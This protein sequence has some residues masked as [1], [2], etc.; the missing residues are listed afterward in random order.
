M[1]QLLKNIKHLWHQQ[2]SFKI[3]LLYLLLLVLLV[4]L[5]PVLP[6]PFGPNELDLDHIFQEPFGWNSGSSSGHRH[7]L[8]SDALG[9]DVLANVL[10]GARSAFII[11]LP[12]MLLSTGIGL[13][14]GLCA[15]FFGNTKLMI[16]RA[17]LMVTCFAAIVIYYLGLYLPLHLY[18]LGFTLTYILFPVLLLIIIVTLLYKVLLPLLR[19]LNL[20]G[21]TTALPLD[22][23]LLRII[24]ALNSIPNLLL[25]LVIASFLPPSVFL[26]SITIIAVSWT[27]TARLARAEI[28][29][30]S[31]LPYFEAAKSIGVTQ[32]QLLI[33]HALPNMLGPVIVTFSFGLAGLLALESTLSFLGIGVPPTFV[34]WGRTIAGIR[35]NTSAWWLVLFPGAALA[36]T[37]LALQTISYH[38]L[39]IIQEKKQ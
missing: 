33:R 31:S 26:L 23:F 16:T 2:P 22:Y 9:R 32:T 4:I 24:E 28:L 19:G 15:G 10:Y 3:A 30:I 21:S 12:V 17:A 38:L 29:K 39:N 7:W 1:K 11:S 13:A 27:S 20:L 35:S 37:V 36:M 14:V 8:G 6:L 18:D 34:S 5:L 25:I